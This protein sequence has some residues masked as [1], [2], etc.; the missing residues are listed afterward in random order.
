MAQKLLV[1]LQVS[2]DLV[3]GLLDSLDRGG[4]RNTAR[5]LIN[6]HWIM[7][8]KLGNADEKTEQSLPLAIAKTK[9]I[10]V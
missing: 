7:G 6:W 3:C 1:R 9:C 4:A 5:I 10:L 8:V 2:I